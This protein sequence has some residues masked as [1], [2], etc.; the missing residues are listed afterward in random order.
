MDVDE[1][2]SYWIDLA[3]YDLETAKAMLKT[4]RFLYIGF[5]CHQSIE[6]AI[7]AYHWKKIKTEPAYIHNLLRLA[8]QS[9]LINHFNESHF[10][11]IN[12]LNPLN[13]EARYPR[14][15]E[16]LLKNLNTQ[17]CEKLLIQTQELMKWIKNKL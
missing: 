14:A 13:I 9:E 2:Y 12:D 1:R 16:E 3:E 8:E 7:K 6:K 4:K 17:K 15:K 10:D 5:M 11:L